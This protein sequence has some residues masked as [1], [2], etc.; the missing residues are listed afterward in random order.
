M[1]EVSPD[2]LLRTIEEYLFENGLS[3]VAGGDR[4]ECPSTVWFPALL[5]AA[6]AHARAHRIGGCV[7][8]LSSSRTSPLRVA[9]TAIATPDPVPVLAAMLD[10]IGKGRN[11]RGELV[12][13]K[14][15]T[16]GPTQ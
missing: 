12:L 9:V 6:D 4:D 13:E 11:A 8:T 14:L 7:L 10:L 1:I 16:E 5:C 2:R 15:V 3:V